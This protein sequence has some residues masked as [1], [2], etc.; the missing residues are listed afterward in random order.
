MPKARRRRRGDG[1]VRSCARRQ[2]STATRM[3][4]SLD[5]ALEELARIEPRQASMVEAASSAASTS[6]RRRTSSASPKQRCS[7]TGAPRERGS[8]TRYDR[9]NS[10]FP[11]QA[12][13]HHGRGSW[14]RIQTIFHH[15][16]DLPPA[17]R[18]AFIDAEA[19][20]DADLAN[21]VKRL[22][23]ADAEAARS[24]TSR[25]RTSRRTS[26]SRCSHRPA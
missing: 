25:S 7:A 12:R 14:Q 23:D 22:L 8:S 3:F 21:D 11:P 15:A 9:L 20:G 5:A 2:R 16:A 18:G 10:A 4:C 19:A 26:W 13:R 24:S 6:P 1:D 17:S